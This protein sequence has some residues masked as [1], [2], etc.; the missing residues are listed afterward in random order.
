MIRIVNLRNYTLNK[1]EILIKVDRSSILG[2]PYFMSDE[3]KRDKVCDDYEMYFINKYSN[4][5]KFR[6]EVDRIVNL[7]KNFD[8]ALGCWCF[9]KRCH[10]TTIKEHIEYV[11]NGDVVEEV[12]DKPCRVIVAGGRDFTDYKLAKEKIDY[13]L[14]DLKGN[15]EIV[16]GMA[17]GSDMLGFKYAM[18]NNK[19]IHSFPAN[20]D[21]FGKRA[22]YIRNEEMAKFSDV[23]IAFWNGRSKGTGHMIE[24]ARQY[25]LGIVVVPYND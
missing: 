18:D 21:K 10:S 3:S 6:N 5:V 24:L 15:Y 11:L 25:K 20:W 12:K 19:K 9:P 8:I 16:C 22:G 14:E 13:Y 7:A 17:R 1:G 2:N 23:L 4:D